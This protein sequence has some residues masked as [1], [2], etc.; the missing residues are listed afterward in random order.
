MGRG[1]AGIA[2]PAWLLPRSNAY[3]YI[4][5]GQY[6]FHAEF[7]SPLLGRL[8][9]SGGLLQATLHTPDPEPGE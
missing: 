8:L 5:D 6:R 3:K 1:M 2:M 9:S 7:S 4:D